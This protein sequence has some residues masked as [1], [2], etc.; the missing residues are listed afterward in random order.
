MAGLLAL[1]ITVIVIAT[2]VSAGDAAASSAPKCARPKSGKVTSKTISA[3]NCTIKYF[4]AV[5]RTYHKELADELGGCPP[6]PGP[7]RWQI[8][9]ETSSRNAAYGEVIE[10]EVQYGI[11]YMATFIASHIAPHYRPGSK[12]ELQLTQAA[13]YYTGLANAWTGSVKDLRAGFS[14]IQA[15]NCTD[16]SIKENDGS[17]EL[18][19]GIKA[20]NKAQTLLADVRRGK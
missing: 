4:Q 2:S 16:G 6:P 11:E 10:N 5:I 1:I 9:D 20:W 3:Y 12:E 17:L 14:A 8:L 18:E 13:S 19:K 7:N 15:H